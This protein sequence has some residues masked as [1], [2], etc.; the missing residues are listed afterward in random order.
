M[1]REA[2]AAV[3]LT[4]VAISAQTAT[5]PYFGV[6]KV[7]P[8]KSELAGTQFTIA[9]TG[10]GE[11]LFTDDVLKKSYKFKMDG[12][13]YADFLGG[14]AAWTQKGDRTWELTYTVNGT[15]IAVETYTV[16][17]DDKSLT[18][19]VAAENKSLQPAQDTV[20]LQRVGSGSGLTGTWKGGPPA[21]PPFELEIQ[22]DAGDGLI[23]RVKGAFETKAKFDGQPYPVT[24]DLVPPAATATFTPTGP[25]SFRMVQ[26][27]G[28]NVVDA[29]VTASEDGNTLTQVAVNQSGDK[30]TWVFER[31]K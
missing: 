23:F 26:N 9:E 28:T 8:Q 6:W 5:A 2:A 11:F 22:P 19:R 13:G 20:V 27:V 31:V 30:M 17:A 4:T 21:A 12:N 1:L 3:V 15:P 25:R 10:G 16:S 7:N 18:T 29:T 14:T 24:G